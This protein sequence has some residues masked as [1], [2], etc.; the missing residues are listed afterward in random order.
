MLSEDVT[1]V[2]NVLV[3]LALG[4]G[5]LSFDYLRLLHLLGSGLRFLFL[6]G[7]LDYWLSSVYLSDE[8]S[9]S[10]LGLKCLRFLFCI[11]KIIR[12]ETI[13]QYV[14]LLRAGCRLHFLFRFDR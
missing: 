8:G 12:L 14:L 13:R 2:S 5:V 6:L 1:K 3:D 11:E 7:L 9:D 4:Y 10:L